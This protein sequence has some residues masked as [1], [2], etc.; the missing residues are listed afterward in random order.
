MIER[1]LERRLNN[2]PKGNCTSSERNT[3]CLEE[4]SICCRDTASCTIEVC[5]EFHHVSGKASKVD[6]RGG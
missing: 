2:F 3:A 4:C 1:R 5:S 6:L